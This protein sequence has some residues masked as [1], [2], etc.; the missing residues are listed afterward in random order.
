MSRFLT[1]FVASGLVAMGW[2]KSKGILRTPKVDSLVVDT[3]VEQGLSII[4]GIGA[5]RPKLATALLGDLY[6]QNPWTKESTASLLRKL[7]EASDVVERHPDIPPWNA[8]WS[9]RR[10]ASFTR[11]MRWSHL[12]DFQFGA[13]LGTTAGRA[14]YWGLTHEDRMQAIFDRLESNYQETARQANH[15]ELAV[16]AQLPWESLE[17]YYEW[18]E[19]FV[20]NFEAARPMFRAIP[21]QLQM[22]PEIKQR[23]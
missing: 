1:W 9:E 21:P 14:V 6:A 10:I 2:P 13:I 4:I 7:G 17:K 22:A 5:G 16:S 11:E 3:V 8:L 20:R 15:Y 18:C 23:L 12:D 19:L